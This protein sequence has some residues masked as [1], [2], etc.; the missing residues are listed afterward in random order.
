MAEATQVANDQL[1]E[2]E[3]VQNRIEKMHKLEERGILP[4]GHR[5]DWTHHNTDVHE[6]AKEMEE[7]GTEVK[8]AGR[9]MAIR[10]HGKTCFM[11]LHDKTGRIQLYLRKDVLGE[12][13]YSVT[14]LMDIGDIIGVTGTV[15]LTHTGEPSIR[16]TDLQFL[17]KALKPLPE[18]FHGLKD[19]DLRYRQRYVDLIMNPEVKEEHPPHSG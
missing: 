10:G 13:A 19:M 17:S 6:H 16:V 5:F 3:Q 14:R 4:F 9:V 1:I 15:F 18:K 8:V 2:N 12:D 11:D 7:A